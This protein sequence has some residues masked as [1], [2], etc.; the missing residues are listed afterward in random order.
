MT[1]FVRSDALAAESL[2]AIPKSYVIGAGEMVKVEGT[3]G[4]AEALKLPLEKAIQGFWKE[5]DYV[6]TVDPKAVNP[7]PIA[8]TLEKTE[9]EKRAIMDKAIKDQAYQDGYDAAK[10][11]FYKG[12][13]YVPEGFI[14]VEELAKI[15]KD[16]ST[17][18]AGV[19]AGTMLGISGA[20]FAVTGYYQLMEGNT[21]TGTSN[22]STGAILSLTSL[23]FLVLSIIAGP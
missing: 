5:N 6:S 1:A 12:P 20:A 22:L 4:R 11:E 9:A 23:P 17:Q 7:V 2:E 3:A 15:R 13:D 21:D 18:R 14:P 16:A 19:I 10:K 8:T